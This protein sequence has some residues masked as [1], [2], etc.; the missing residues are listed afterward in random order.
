MNAPNL[1][2]E[3]FEAGERFSLNFNVSELFAWEFDV[4]V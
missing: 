3:T 2:Y 4:G 1:K